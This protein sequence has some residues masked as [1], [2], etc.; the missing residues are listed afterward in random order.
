MPGE[1]ATLVSPIYLEILA[2]RLHD[3]KRQI[4]FGSSGG[5]KL[6]SPGGDRPFQVISSSASLTPDRRE[7]VEMA[8][9]ARR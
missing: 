2:P 4:N 9:A 1:M 3:V 5:S 8:V 7:A 6:G